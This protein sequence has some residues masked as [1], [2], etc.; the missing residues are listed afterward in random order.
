MAKVRVYEL[1]RELGVDNKV[2]IQKAQELGFS[3]V[4]SHS[5]SLSGDEIDS[6]RRAFIREAIGNRP[7]SE[8]VKKTVDSETGEMATIVERRKGDVVRRRRRDETT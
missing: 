1:A 7:D 2:V 6:L 4:R 5:N 3:S 8:V